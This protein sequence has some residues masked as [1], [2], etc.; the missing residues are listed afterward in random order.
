MKKNLDWVQHTHLI[1]KNY[2]VIYLELRKRCQKPEQREDFND[3]TEIFYLDPIT[4][5]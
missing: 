2:T 4:L 5:I 1:E 3:I